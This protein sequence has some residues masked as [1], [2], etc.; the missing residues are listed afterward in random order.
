M[1]KVEKNKRGLTTTHVIVQCALKKEKKFNNN[2]FQEEEGEKVS[3]VL[4]R[5]PFRFYYLGSQNQIFF[6]P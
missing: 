5:G 2:V 3:K 4:F 1:I 6:K